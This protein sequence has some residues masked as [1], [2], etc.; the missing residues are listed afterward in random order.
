MEQELKAKSL[1]NS[2][3]ALTAAAH[4]PD[5]SNP[6]GLPLRMV[7]VMLTHFNLILHALIWSYEHAKPLPTPQVTS[8]ASHKHVTKSSRLRVRTPPSGRGAALAPL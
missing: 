6:S 2:G 7:A 8:L 3:W 1:E 4:V 5:D